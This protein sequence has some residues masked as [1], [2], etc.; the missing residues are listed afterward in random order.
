MSLEEARRDYKKKELL[1]VKCAA[2][3]VR[4]CGIVDSSSSSSTLDLFF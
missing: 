2:S 3:L 4:N 1:R